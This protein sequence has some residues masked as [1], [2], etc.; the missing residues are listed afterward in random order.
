MYI[1]TCWVCASQGLTKGAAGG[2]T[3]DISPQMRENGRLGLRYQSGK[4][5]D[6]YVG[7]FP[8]CST[9]IPNIFQIGLPFSPP[10]LTANTRIHSLS[11]H[12]GFPAYD[13]DKP[14]SFC[15]DR[16]L[17]TWSAEDTSDAN[18]AGRRDA[19]VQSAAAVAEKEHE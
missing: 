14:L 10:V 8:S 4:A 3:P 5:E 12:F 6:R 11:S 2:S 18:C 16:H 9:C 19:G 7:A 13:V 15:P 1:S 17:S